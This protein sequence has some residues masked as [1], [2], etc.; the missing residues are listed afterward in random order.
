M[1]E[2]QGL[3]QVAPQEGQPQG[4][5]QEAPKCTADTAMQINDSILAKASQAAQVA[6]EGRNFQP[7]A[8]IAQLGERPV[9]MPMMQEPQA[10]SPQEQEMLAMQDSQL[11]M[12][13]MPV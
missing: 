13:G 2:Q 5:P 12:G 10:V 7:P 3:G 4:Q 6:K 1:D 8:Q 9:G 11:N